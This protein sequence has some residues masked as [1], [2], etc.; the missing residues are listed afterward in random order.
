MRIRYDSPPIYITENGFD[1]P[2][3]SELTGDAALDDQKRVD[4]LTVRLE[5]GF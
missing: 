3:E 4:Y 2:G 5:A 1:V